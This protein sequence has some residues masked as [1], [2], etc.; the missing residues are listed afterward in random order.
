MFD[1]NGMILHLLSYLTEE[2]WI[3]AFEKQHYQ[4]DKD[5]IREYAQIIARQYNLQW[6][7]KMKKIFKFPE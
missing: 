4:E 2:Q 1:N 7:E 3:D 5:S 6:S